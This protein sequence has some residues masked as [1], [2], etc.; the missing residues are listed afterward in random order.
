MADFDPV[1]GPTDRRDVLRALG[2]AGTAGLFGS[3]SMGSVTAQRGFDEAYYENPLYGPDF[4]DPTIQRADDGTWWAYASNMS[5]IDDADERLVPIL[6]SPDL[7]DWTYAGEAFDSRPGWAYGSIWAPDVHYHDGQWVLFYSLWPRNDGEGDQ[8]GIGVA[9]SDTPD[10]PF[11]D[12]G[13]LF[14]NPEH[15]FPG[16]TIDPYFVSHQGTPYLFWGN[17]AGIYYV[18]LTAELQNYRPGTWGQ[19]VGSAYEGST[20]FQR[21]GYWYFFGSTGDCCDGF[22]S[23]YEI[24]V[25]RS[26]NLLGPY[27]DSDGTPMMERN[28]WN[29]GPT[30]L[31]DNDRFVAPGHG[32]VTVDDDGSYWFVYHAYDTQGLETIDNGWPPA[33]QL[34]LDRI[35]WSNGWPVIAGDGT[36][37]ATAPIPNLGQRPAPVAEGT[38]NVVNVQSGHYLGIAGTGDGATATVATNDAGFRAAWQLRRLAGGEYVLN[39]ADSGQTLEV[40]NADTSDGADVQQWPWNGHPT[41]RWY[42]FEESDGTYRMKNACSGKVAEVANASAAAGANVQQWTWNDGD[43]QRWRFVPIEDDG[44]GGSSG[45]GGTSGSGSSTTR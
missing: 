21:D 33:R 2:G 10:G 15:P 5:Y 45:S 27:A 22:D 31:G 7:V 1:S 35:Y 40:V 30:H 3:V 34:F 8:T 37:N 42:C 13:R 16:N 23:T 32:D 29:A 44:S 11:T 9:T 41:Q 20:I 39:N 12:H 14:T 4:A 43:H 38:Y 36:P 25:G 17:F 26:E 6:S 19:I 28:E 18:E 24:E